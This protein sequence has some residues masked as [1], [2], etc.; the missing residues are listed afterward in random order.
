MNS[1]QFLNIR[2]Y[3]TVTALKSKRHRI[4]SNLE[5]NSCLLTLLI[6]RFC[7]AGTNYVTEMFSFKCFSSCASGHGRKPIE[8]IFTLEDAET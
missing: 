2:Q 3:R 8:I 1:V 7:I 4:K 6:S 5:E